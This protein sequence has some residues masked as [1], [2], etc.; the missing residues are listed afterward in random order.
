MVKKT[1]YN[2]KVREIENK[3]NDHNHDEYIDTS[4]FTTLATNV[5]NMRIAQANLITK[6]VLMLNY[7]CL[8]EKLLKI[9][10]IMYLLKMN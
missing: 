7:Q 1:D 9:N 4:K 2:T 10:Q 8:T 5:F 3:L 6:T